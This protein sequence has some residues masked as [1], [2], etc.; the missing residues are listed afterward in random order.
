MISSQSGDVVASAQKSV[1]FCADNA[2]GKVQ[3]VE[4]RQEI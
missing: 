3:K 2:K 1:H 4:V